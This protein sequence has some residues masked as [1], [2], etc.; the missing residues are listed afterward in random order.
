MKRN[1]K[2]IIAVVTFSMATLVMTGF[3]K[4]RVNL[5]DNGTVLLDRMSS[6]EASVYNVSVLQEGDELIIRGKVKH[7]HRTYGFNS[8]GHVDIAIF[9]PDGG[10]IKKASLRTNPRTL[11]KGVLRRRAKKA[12]FIVRLPIVP[13]QNTKVRIAHHIRKYPADKV[14]DCGQN[15][16]INP[17]G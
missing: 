10:I 1:V 17:Q 11:H 2:H 6:E 8:R 9:S 13:L 14:F 12:S 3:S 15:A 4:R 5:I 16:A 7:R